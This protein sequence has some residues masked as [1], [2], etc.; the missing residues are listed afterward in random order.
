MKFSYRWFREM[1]GDDRLSLDEACELLTRGGIEVEEILDAGFVSGRI[2]V[3]EA[4]AVEPHPNADKLRL[5]TVATGSGPG[6]PTQKVVCGAPNVRVGGRYPLALIGAK[7]FNGSMIEPAS[8]RG[9]ESCGMLCS[10]VELGWGSDSAGLLELPET[11]EP[12]EPVDAIVD[13]KIT[14]DRPDC[15]SIYGIARDAAGLLGRRLEFPAFSLK[16]EAKESAKDFASVQVLDPLGCPRY[17]ARVVR[18]VKIGPSPL[19]M[20]RRLESC[21]VRP[22]NNIVDITN[23]VMLETGHPLHG[24]D[25]DR[26]AGGKIVVRRAHPAERLKLLDDTDLTLTP[27]D[28]V[29]ADAERAHVLAG[30]MGG[31]ES[32]V[33]DGTQNVLIECACFEPTIIRRASKRHNK[34]SESSYRFERGVNYHDMARSI[35]RAAQL[36]AQLAGGQAAQGIVDV[37]APAPASPRIELRLGKCRS[38]LGV[39]LTRQRVQDALWPLGFEM[40]GGDD[41]KISVSPADFRLDISMEADV[42]EEVA[43][44]VG[45]EAIANTLPKLDVNEVP[46][47]PLIVWR[48]RIREAMMGMGFSEA[49]TYSF[50]DPKRV[51]LFAS[52]P[53]ERW[54]LELHNPLSPEQSVMR[55]ALAPGL[56]EAASLNQRRQERDVMLFEVANVFHPLHETAPPRPDGKKPLAAD[57]SREETRVAAVWG[58]SAGFDWRL[59]RKERPVDFFDMKGVAE[60][61]LEVL[62]V[63]AT[64]EADAETPWLHPGRAGRWVDDQGRVLLR[65]GQLHP[66]L[67]KTFKLRDA[68]LYLIEGSVNLLAE[69]STGLPEHRA[70]PTHPAVA[71]DLALVA[72]TSVSA[73]ALEKVIF[74]EGGDWLESVRLVDVYEGEQ[75]PAGKRS[76]AFGL[77]FRAPER[78]LTDEEVNAAVDKIISRASL[79]HGAELRA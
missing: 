5:V 10:G 47:A 63:Q 45:Y 3:G 21:G 42:L 55:R 22:I 78:S 19:W 2:V 71:R 50:D 25:L 24:F 32:E 54:V 1:L 6:A 51:E 26:L 58:G 53:E 73:G 65:V 37:A 66:D 14:P 72:Q 46:D 33:H 36:M 27:H 61:L 62:R 39:D 11:L 23:Y 31:A 57:L 56:L 30:V 15:L 8:I 60:A 43:R 48:H 70:M 13:V 59:P 44:F 12:G 69:A 40:H 77:T 76:L 34:S 4:R 64:F 7:M 52:S 18:G 67:A 29:I 17:M 74:A 28:L 68:A 35:D 41:E 49:L 9:V 79:E 16:E 20:R 38:F 75:V